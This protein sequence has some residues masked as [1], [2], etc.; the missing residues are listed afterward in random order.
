MITDST[1]GVILESA[2]AS[3]KLPI[4]SLTKIATAMVVLDWADAKKSDLNQLVAIPPSVS[5]TGDGFG[6]RFSDPETKPRCAISS[7]LR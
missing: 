5:R 3:K 2:N 1:T 4:A 7:T 6:R